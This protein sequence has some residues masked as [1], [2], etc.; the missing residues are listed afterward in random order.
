MTNIFRKTPKF[1]AATLFASSLLLSSCSQNENLENLETVNQKLNTKSHSCA[2]GETNN[3]LQ[4]R[5]NE[6]L[7][8]WFG[9]PINTTPRRTPDGQT[10]D[11]EVVDLSNSNSREFN[12]PSFNSIHN[13]RVA[14][15]PDVPE[16]WRLAFAYATSRW[17]NLEINGLKIVNFN[18]VDVALDPGNPDFSKYD[19]VLSYRNDTFIGGSIAGATFPSSLGKVGNIININ[20][21]DDNAEERSFNLKAAIMAHEIGHTLGI[22]HTASNCGLTIMSPNYDNIPNVESWLDFTASEKQELSLRLK[23]IFIIEHID[24]LSGI[25]TPINNPTLFLQLLDLQNNTSD[26]TSRFSHCSS[27][28]SDPLTNNDIESFFNILQS[29]SL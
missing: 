20:P 25:I 16:D 18:F 2:N 12:I 6:S 10:I 5:T 28:S 7:G 8:N 26:Y 21:F 4:T 23:L 19:L 11:I 3:L 24:I 1:L 27:Q 17:S 15:H 22:H 13:I 29:G 14:V 9:Y